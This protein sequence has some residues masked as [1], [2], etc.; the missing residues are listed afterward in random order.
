LDKYVEVIVHTV[1]A[2]VFL[3]I[4]TR[5]MGKKQI[6][7]MTFFD[8]V[9]G[10][11]IGSVSAN[12]SVTGDLSFFSGLSSIFLW[13]MLPLIVSYL[14]LH[15]KKARNILVGVPTILVQNGLLIPENLKKAR[16]SVEDVLEQL[17][18]K[19]AY[20]ISDVDIAMLENS[21]K[22]SVLFKPGKQP[23]S[24]QAVNYT[25]AY[26]GLDTNIIINGKLMRE[27]LRTVGKDEQWLRQE[28]GKQGYASCEN[29]LLACVDAQNALYISPMHPS[30][31]IQDVL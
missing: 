9:A 24:M 17:R 7:Q 30:H 29:I 6:S 25:P 20:Y 15:K 8:Y 3:F 1:T 13:A 11:A 16:L 12:F 19:N 10:I 18:L 28:M 4:M 23:V 26:R 21:G 5:L 22:V 14:T 2:I 31:T 27:N